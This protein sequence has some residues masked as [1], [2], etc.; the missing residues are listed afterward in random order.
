[1]IYTV[2]KIHKNKENPPGRPIVNG[3]N[4]VTARLGEY[5]DNF[6]QPAIQC[7]TAYLKDTKHVLQL[8]DSP[9]VLEGRTL[10][11]TA[12]V[13]SLYT[14]I[15]HHQ[16]C[17]ATK[18]V[19]KHF[20]RLH[21]TQRKYLIKCIDFSLKNNY[22]WHQ[23]KFY[24]QITGIAMGTKYAPSVANAFMAQWEEEVVHNNTPCQLELYKRFIDDILI[25][26]NGDKD[27]LE[28]FL[29]G[30]NQDDRN[31]TL[32][33]TIDTKQIQFLDLVIS[34]E[35]NQLTTKTYFKEVTR[36]SYLP[37]TS[38]HHKPWLFNIPKGQLIRVKRNCTK[39]SDYKIQ[40]DLI[41]RRFL[42][43]GY[44]SEFIKQQIYQFNL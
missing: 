31:I 36:N 30:L 38:C 26:W 20:T 21:H 25:V 44:D 15:Q 19:L 18:W 2:P 3:I 10:L 41:G 29:I 39:E 14:I 24:K 23:Q 7:T 11:A 33:W 9:M 8:L 28:Q 40:A 32:T 4:S 16:A 1:M 22:F 35:N 37:I 17:E 13:S 43:K 6:I 34:I 42:E 5:I 27:S 12:D